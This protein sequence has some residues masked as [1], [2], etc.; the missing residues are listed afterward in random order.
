MDLPS[1]FDCFVR[2]RQIALRTD[3]NRNSLLFVGGTNALLKE[4]R[5]AYGLYFKNWKSEKR[6]K[7][8][9]SL[10]VKEEC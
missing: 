4:K 2:R 10:Q 8:P 7:G 6:S 5:S 1:T 3:C 9:P